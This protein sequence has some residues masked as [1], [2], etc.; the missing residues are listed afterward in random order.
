MSDVLPIG[1]A[2]S[3][4][5]LFI[6]LCTP[7]GAYTCEELNQ[8]LDCE[9]IKKVDVVV[10]F[11]TTGS[12]YGV[13]EQMK[14]NS[15][16]FANA[17]SSSGIDYRLGLT[18]FDDFPDVCGGD[19]GSSASGDVPYNIFNGGQLTADPAEFASWVNTL[20]THFGVDAPESHLAA[21]HHTVTDQLWRG[22]DVQKV[23]I[24]ITDAPPHA[25]GECCN[26]EGDTYDGIKSLL[27]ASG[28]RVFV[29]GPNMDWS[30]DLASSTGGNFYSIE[31]GDLM[32]ILSDIAQT[33][34]CSFNLDAEAQCQS[35]QL[36][37]CVR[38]TGKDGI[39]IPHEPELTYWWVVIPCDEE[40]TVF[41]LAYDEAKGAYCA[42]IDP[43]CINGIDNVSLN[44]VGEICGVMF[45][46]YLT[47]DCCPEEMPEKHALPEPVQYEQYCE[48]GLVEGSGIIDISTS[49]KDKRLA[50]EYSNAMAG[51]GDIELSSE[52]VMS[53]NAS[54]LQRPGANGSQNV[55]LNFYSASKMQYR[56]ETPLMG[57]KQILSRS[58]YGGIGADLREVFSTT[59][60][61]Q[62]ERMFYAST[63]PAGHWTAGKDALVEGTKLSDLV[64]SSPVYLMGLDTRNQFNGTWGT[65]SRWHKLLH[66]DIVDHQ[67]FT[68]TFEAEKLI[69]FH[70]APYKEMMKPPC[71]GV[72]C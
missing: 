39:L 59:E 13:I 15:I 49:I 48:N 61:E 24:L 69:K 44:L 34:T 9:S 12:M 21:L 20:V 70:E 2:L 4:A 27:I 38:M 31:S 10:V 1:K 68:G 35:G 8:F 6:A 66:K 46:K 57:G 32:P 17:L 26:Y 63:D 64:N 62:D 30:Y 29:V 40:I 47:L 14:T 50:L 56:G 28:V 71:L 22:G 53:E 45:N 18:Q 60:M 37:I 36:D 52:H 41:E 43:V 72:D 23:V 7:G 51:N 5:L 42:S 54:K 58:F 65:D 11:D 25:D 55:P 3:L 33:L 19:C 16:N 67:M